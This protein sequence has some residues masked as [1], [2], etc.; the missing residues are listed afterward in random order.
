M[1]FFSG[2]FFCLGRNCISRRSRGLDSWGG[3]DDRE[4][5]LRLDAIK[6]EADRKA[7]QAKPEGGLPAFHEYQPLAAR[8]DGEAVYLEAYK[9]NHSATM[10]SG[11]SSRTG[12]TPALEGTRA[13]DG[14]YDST[15]Y[16]PSQRPPRR[17][18]SATTATTS[19]YSSV[20]TTVSPPPR[21]PSQPFQQPLTSSPP[22]LDQYNN[23]SQYDPYSTPTQAY[24]HGQQI[25]S[26][27][28]FLLPTS[29][30]KTYCIAVSTV[31]IHQQQ[32]SAQSNYSQ[33]YNDPY[34]SHHLQ[35]QSSY[36]TYNAPQAQHNP[37]VR[38]QTSFYTSPIT[39]PE[40]QR[41]HTLGGAGY[42][43]P[44]LPEPQFDYSAPPPINTNVGYSSPLDRSPVKGPRAQPSSSQHEEPPPGYDDGQEHW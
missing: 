11:P 38:N 22:P 14:Y 33:Q 16:P 37:P 20:P 28:L 23:A 30:H 26:C 43:S 1:L 9:D 19:L 21:Q 41:S 13:I 31:P 35:H 40:P 5:R 27:K 15:A 29:S 36:H 7:L 25:S 4:E 24:G 3:R 18:N 32:P 42:S 12:Y 6:A 39:S 34:A 17:Q 44:P 10:S 8:V 2:F